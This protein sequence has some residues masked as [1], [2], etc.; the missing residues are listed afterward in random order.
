MVERNVVVTT[1]EDPM[2][3][4]YIP[5]VEPHFIYPVKVYNGAGELTRIVPV[6]ELIHDIY[7]EFK[8]RA[9]KQPIV[10]HA[11]CAYCGDRFGKVRKK[12]RFCKEQVPDCQQQWTKADKKDK[13]EA[14]TVTRNCRTCKKDFTT[15]RHTKVYCNDPCK[16]A[17][18]AVPPVR[19]VECAICYKIYK[20]TRHNSRFCGKPCDSA[21][22][23]RSKNKR[24]TQI[25]NVKIE[26]MKTARSV[27]SGI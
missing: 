27:E 5:V 25:K 12:Q 16:S 23:R 18:K 2:G 19:T 4:I 24:Q 9:R 3:D 8:P 7:K 14:K 15:H 20:T 26:C 22:L 11:N 21:K 13:R 17:N 1:D 10:G 6:E